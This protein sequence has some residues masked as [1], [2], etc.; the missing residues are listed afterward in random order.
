MNRII[1]EAAAHQI[2]VAVVAFIIAW[3]G[4]GLL[5]ANAN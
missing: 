1:L 4:F 3:Q 2:V 5:L